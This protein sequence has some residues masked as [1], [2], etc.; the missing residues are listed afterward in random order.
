VDTEHQ[1][2]LI[3]NGYGNYNEVTID[4]DYNDRGELV[5]VT[6]KVNNNTYTLPDRYFEVSYDD[7]AIE[8]RTGATSRTTP[9]GHLHRQRAH[10]YTGKSN[11]AYQN[12]RGFG[13]PATYYYFQLAYPCSG[14]YYPQ[15][16]GGGSDL[17]SEITRP[18]AAARRTRPKLICATSMAIL[19]EPIPD[20]HA[21]ERNAAI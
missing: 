9:Q 6:S 3:F 8:R 2:G 12:A 17:F 7:A 20:L 4:H 18:A 11:R 19:R 5:K 21:R 15:Q 1:T 13:S 16:Q 10:Q 14:T